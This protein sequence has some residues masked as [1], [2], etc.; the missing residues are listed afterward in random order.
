MT[1]W[2]LSL[3]GKSFYDLYIALPVNRVW[4]LT[5]KIIETNLGKEGKYVCDMCV[6]LVWSPSQYSSINNIGLHRGIEL[7][8]WS[9]MCKGYGWLP[10]WSLLTIT[11]IYHIWN[12]IGNSGVK[13]THLFS[14]HI[15]IQNTCLRGLPGLISG[16]FSSIDSNDMNDMMSLWAYSL[17]FKSNIYG[18]QRQTSI[19]W[20]Q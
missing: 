10:A 19:Q 9:I 7:E 20:I 3:D 14:R 8:E 12:T 18:L 11:N 1:F 15:A 2:M 17:K 13:E 5:E 4:V 6:A 16:I